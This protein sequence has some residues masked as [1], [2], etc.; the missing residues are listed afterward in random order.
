MYISDRMNSKTSQVK[1]EL[2]Y[3][4]ASIALKTPPRQDAID[5]KVEMHS[6]LKNFLSTDPTGA[7]RNLMYLHFNLNIFSFT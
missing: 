4:T 5:N 2:C 3:Y 1:V 6:V 7:S